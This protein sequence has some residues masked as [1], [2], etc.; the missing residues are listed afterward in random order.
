MVNGWRRRGD[1]STATAARP[2]PT[3]AID[4]GGPAS[5]QFNRL[6][7]STSC[8]QVQQTTHR[9]QEWRRTPAC[10]EMST[11]PITFRQ[12]THWQ[13]IIPQSIKKFPLSPN[14]TRM[15]REPGWARRSWKRA[16]WDLSLSHAALYLHL[17]H[18][19]IHSPTIQILDCYPEILGPKKRSLLNGNHVLATTGKSC[20]KKKSAF[21][22]IIKGENVILGDFLG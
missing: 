15:P 2:L 20:S 21:V 14:S 7:P 11:L 9:L 8:L 13:R 3:T 18:G 6:N 12:K 17:H 19:Y 5:S 16:G 1:K 22:Q 10:P 4:Q